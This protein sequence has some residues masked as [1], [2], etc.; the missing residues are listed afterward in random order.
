MANIIDASGLSGCFRCHFVWR[1][2]TQDPTRCPRCKSTLWDVP[3]LSKVRRGGGAGIKEVLEPHRHKIG[4]AV[5]RNR[6]T[7]LR[8]FGSVAASRAGSSSDV[9]LIVDFEPGATAFDQIG[10]A[11]D[12]EAILGRRVE[13]VTDRGLHWIIRPQVLFE[14]IPYELHE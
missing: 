6:G 1:P 12:L 3:K 2:R 14:A 7:H 5:R 4:E 10:L 9:D 8:V 11:Q 13:V